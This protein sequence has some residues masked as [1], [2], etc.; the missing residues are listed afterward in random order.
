MYPLY[1]ILE[2]YGVIKL[3]EYD[4]FLNDLHLMVLMDDTVLLGATRSMITKKFSILM[5]FCEKY[6]MAVNEV[7]QRFL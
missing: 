3:V 6:G 1:N 2:C 4:S 7:K 5:E